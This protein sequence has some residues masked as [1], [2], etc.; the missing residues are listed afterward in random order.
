MTSASPA[1]GQ[2][3]GGDADV[4]LGPGLSV[5]GCALPQ[6]LIIMMLIIMKKQRLSSRRD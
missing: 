4:P 2:A 1:K 5:T 3:T 6:P